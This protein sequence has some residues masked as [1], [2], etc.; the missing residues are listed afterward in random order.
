MLD[1]AC[2]TRFF[3]L[4]VGTEVRHGHRSAAIP[5]SGTWLLSST[6]GLLLLGQ[7]RELLVC[8]RFLSLKFCSSGG[9][10]CYSFPVELGVCIDVRDLYLLRFGDDVKH[11]GKPGLSNLVDEDETFQLDVV[12]AFI[13]SRSDGWFIFKQ[14][15][16]ICVVAL[17]RTANI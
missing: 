11:V 5:N 16:T 8:L 9:S 4:G 2:T 12:D 14:P 7:R 6:F 13:G 17:S 3:S 15:R 10:F 1:S